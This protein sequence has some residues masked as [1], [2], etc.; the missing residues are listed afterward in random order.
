MRRGQA[1]ITAIEAGIGVLLVTSLALA[2]VLG[3]STG[4]PTSQA[5]LDSYAADTATILT[6]EQPRHADQTR[7]AELTAS[8]AAFEREGEAVE[9]RVEE[10]LPGNVLFRIETP[11]GSLGHPL[12]GDVQ[13]SSKTV[14]T[15]NGSVTLEVWYV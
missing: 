1:T 5:Q 12:P 10:I 14:P 4:G 3:P 9:R 7:L 8:E 11:H 6:H 13:H 15:T 2:F